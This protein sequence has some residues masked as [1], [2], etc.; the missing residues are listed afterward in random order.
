MSLNVI[1]MKW[2]TKYSSEYVNKLYSMVARN[3]SLPFRFV[4]FTDDADGIKDGVEIYSLPSVQIPDGSPERGW[5]KLAVFG[6][7]EAQLK[8][9]CLFLDFDVVSVGGLDQFYEVDSTF[10][11]AF[12]EKKKKSKIGNSSV[13]LFE[14]LHFKDIL[15][16]FNQNAQSI[17]KTYRNEQAY[18]SDM[19]EKKDELTFFPKEWCPSFKYHCIPKFPLNFLFAPK[20][21]ENSKIILFH[22]KPEPIDAIQGR[23]GK[24]FR[25]IKKT[26]W[27]NEY[28]CED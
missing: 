27:I 26:L 24:W 17:L 25:Y 16:N 8:G 2:G 14:A 20:V 3:L 1:C 9:R 4:C 13:F 28:W 18:L 19:M 22:G 11:L 15:N 10:C 21:P 6:E 7:T 23:S 5:R 12:D